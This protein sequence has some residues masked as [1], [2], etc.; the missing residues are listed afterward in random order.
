M[1]INE[2]NNISFININEKEQQFFESS[3]SEFIKHIKTRKCGYI[4]LMTH[5]SL[6]T[7][8]QLTHEFKNIIEKNG[9]LQFY[10]NKYEMEFKNDPLKKKINVF[11]FR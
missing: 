4:V 11:I 5:N 10:K 9:Y 7:K 6:N 8:P 2:I 3:I 1:N